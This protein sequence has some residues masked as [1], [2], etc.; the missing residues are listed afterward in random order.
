MAFTISVNAVG[1]STPQLRVSRIISLGNMADKV[2]Q[3]RKLRMRLQGNLDMEESSPPSSHCVGSHRAPQ[4]RTALSSGGRVEVLV[5]C[6][7]LQVSKVFVEMGRNQNMSVCSQSERRTRGTR[8][9]F[10]GQKSRAPL[11]LWT[12]GLGK[13][14]R[15]V[16]TR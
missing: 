6:S 15:E 13:H 8:Q 5:L 2:T 4:R 9:S 1:W 11:V 12:Q 16:G 3:S 7:R 14:R 10:L